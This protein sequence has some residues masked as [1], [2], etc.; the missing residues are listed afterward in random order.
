VAAQGDPGR[1]YTGDR[2][3]AQA[4]ALRVHGRQLRADAFP[5]GRS[6]AYPLYARRAGDSLA[7]WPRYADP[8][9]RFPFRSRSTS[10]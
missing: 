5:V 6:K 9:R 8:T 10:C 3:A 2:A 7:L 4:S 1:L